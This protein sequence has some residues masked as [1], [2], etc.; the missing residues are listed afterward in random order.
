MRRF[1]DPA[2]NYFVFE[3][4]GEEQVIRKHEQHEGDN[5]LPVVGEH[6]HPELNEYQQEFERAHDID[7]IVRFSEHFLEI[8]LMGI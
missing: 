6:K 4:L 1:V 2:Q 7:Q 5:V 3:K 8:F